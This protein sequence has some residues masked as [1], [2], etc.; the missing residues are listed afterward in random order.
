MI[1]YA[2]VEQKGNGAK[3]RYGERPNHKILIFVR[4]DQ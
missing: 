3:Q 2:S 1:F 4:F